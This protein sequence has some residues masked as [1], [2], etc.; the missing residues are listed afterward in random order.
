[1]HALHGSEFY[2][3]VVYCG[4]FVCFNAEVVVNLCWCGCASQGR[5]EMNNAVVV[6]LVWEISSRALPLPLPLALAF[7]FGFGHDVNRT[8][9]T[10]T[11]RIR[12]AQKRTETHRNAQKRTETHRNAQKRT[13]T[14]RNAQ[15]RTE[16]HRN[17]QKR[18]ETHRNAQKRTETHNQLC[19]NYANILRNRC[20]LAVSCGFLW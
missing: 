12:N 4:Y 13:E 20:L 19:V 9:C 18:T 7:A 8:Y 15:K 14:H 6:M 16:T 17:A 10:E 11:H 1:M 3:A 2:L 5:K